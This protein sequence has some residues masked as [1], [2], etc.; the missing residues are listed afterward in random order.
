MD[1]ALEDHIADRGFVYGIG[2]QLRITSLSNPQ[3]EKNV[4]YSKAFSTFLKEKIGVE[5]DR[6][7]ILFHELGKCNIYTSDFP[8]PFQDFQT[9]HSSASNLVASP[10]PQEAFAFCPVRD[11]VLTLNCSGFEYWIQR[12]NLCRYHEGLVTCS[13]VLAETRLSWAYEYAN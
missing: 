9:L 1:K 3:P 10:R 7:Y 13:E 8:F 2:F 5:N 6:G 12:N 11:L 4:S